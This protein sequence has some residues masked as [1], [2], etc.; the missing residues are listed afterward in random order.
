LKTKN[1]QISKFLHNKKHFGKKKLVSSQRKVKISS[2]KSK[3]K[4]TR[5]EKVTRKKRAGE[6]KEKSGIKFWTNYKE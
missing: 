3:S 6:K 5:N 1:V 2:L 4:Q